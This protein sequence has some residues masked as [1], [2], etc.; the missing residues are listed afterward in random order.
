MGK[1]VMHKARRNSNGSFSVGKTWSLDDTRQVEQLGVGSF[2]HP[3]QLEANVP[4]TASALCLDN[5][6]AD[7]PVDN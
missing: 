3:Y 2:F 6:A 5:D 7:V 1:C 4:R